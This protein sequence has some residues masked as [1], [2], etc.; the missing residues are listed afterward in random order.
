MPASVQSEE[1]DAQL[2]YIDWMKVAW[3]QIRQMLEKSSSYDQKVGFYPAKVLDALPAPGRGW[4]EGQKRERVIAVLQVLDTLTER[5]FLQTTGSTPPRYL[6]T[7]NTSE[8]YWDVDSR[9]KPF[10]ETRLKEPMQWR[11]MTEFNKQAQKAG[12]DD[13]YVLLQRA[14][15]REA[16]EAIGGQLTEITTEKGRRE[17]QQFLN[18]LRIAQMVKDVSVTTDD[19]Y[20]WPTYRGLFYTRHLVQ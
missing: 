10:P 18:T 17:A 3:H 13:A 14:S 9:F 11:F 4:T 6:S 15:F 2:D 7:D 19:I 16:S 1:R 5:G 12:P 20:A 8:E